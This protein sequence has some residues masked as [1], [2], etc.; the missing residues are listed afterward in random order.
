MANNWPDGGEQPLSRGEKLVMG[1]IGVALV[2]LFVGAVL[3]AALAFM[4]RRPS[5]IEL[6]VVAAI[7]VAVGLLWVRPWETEAPQ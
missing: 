4:G 1:A 2:G 6:G 3:F 7:G 5:A